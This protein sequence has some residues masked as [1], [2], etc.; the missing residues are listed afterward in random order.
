MNRDMIAGVAVLDA[1]T[2]TLYCQARRADGEIIPIDIWVRPEGQPRY[3]EPEWEYKVVGDTL[4]VRP[5]VHL[6]GR[7]FHNDASWSVRFVKRDREDPAYK[8]HP[9][10][11]LRAV[12]APRDGTRLH[13]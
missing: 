4:H 2:G 6:P 7:G 13:D 8:D 11:Q 9:F 1:E 5:S 12:N 10:M 3:R